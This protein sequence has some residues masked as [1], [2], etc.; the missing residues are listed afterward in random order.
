MNK[1]KLFLLKFLSYRQAENLKTYFSIILYYS[2]LAYLISLFADKGA[3]I[4]IYHSINDKN[5]F[6]DNIVYPEIFERQISYLSKRYNIVPLSLLVEYLYLKKEIPNNWIILTFDDG[7]RDNLYNVLPILKRYKAA[8]TFYVTADAVK[9]RMI[10]F[11]DRIQSIIEAAK[12]KNIVVCLDNK[13]IKFSLSDKKRREDAVLSIVLSIREKE[14]KTQRRFIEYLQKICESE[15]IP[16]QK[17]PIYLTEDEVEKLHKSGME[18]GSHTISHNNL[19]RLSQR[20][21]DKEISGSKETLEEIIGSKITAFSYPFGK[22]D[23]YNNSIKEMVKQ[24]GYRSAVTTIFG[25]VNL[26]SDLYA[27]PRIG[28]RNTTVTRLKVNLMGIHI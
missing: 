10:F 22:K 9:N 24:A 20:E 28:V 4:L 3:S 7:Y 19:K 21:L 17:S 27:L 12:V 15:T 14:S 18:I 16:Y 2:G 13:Q 1:C 6:T 11:Y 23:T 25:K 5:I 26:D 8:A